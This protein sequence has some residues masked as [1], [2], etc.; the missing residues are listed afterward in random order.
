VTAAE[1]PGRYGAVIDIIPESGRPMR[2]F[3]TLFRQ[4]GEFGEFQWW[5]YDADAAFQLPK[6]T[7]IDAAVLREQ[8]RV[9]SGHLKWQF[10][11]GLFRDW[12]SGPLLAGLAETRPGSGPARLAED[13]FARDRQWWVGLKRKL[14]GTDRQ[15][16]K[17]FT[18]PRP[19]NGTPAPVLREGTPAEAGMKPDTAERIEAVCRAWEA[20]TDQAFAVCVARRGV[21][22]FHKAYGQ[23]DGKPMTLDTKSW[24]ASITKLLSGTLMMMVVDQG[25][26]DLDDRVD[27]FIPVLRDVPVKKP[28]TIRH[29]YTHTNGL[30][31]HWGDDLNDFEE[32]IAGYYPHL[33]VGERHSYNGA[34]YTLGGKVIEAVTG[35]SIPQFFKRHLLDPLGCANTDVI[36]TS[37]GSQSAALDIARIGQMLLNRGAYGNLRFFR[38]ETFQK[39]LPQ[40]LTAVLGPDT[41]L[42][43]GIG[44]TWFNEKGLG[45]GAFG[46][47]AASSATLRIDPVNDL[48]IVMTR[49]EAGRNFGKYHDQF[50]NA[51]VEGLPTSATE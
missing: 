21:I 39:M 35:E 15:F 14:Y 19:I 11:S 34:G 46:H 31:G 12:H 30:W 38:E 44:V 18:C 36:D 17:P 25:L 49:N 26:V 23:R 4:P 8:A 37:G 24:M 5:R 10:V 51:I 28:L 6:E 50:I 33:K 7:G 40:S 2:R 48:V 42:E 32:I 45:K 16:S 13:V 27:K 9:M 3:R 1:K 22:F 43:W 29:L 41:N 47:G 20:D